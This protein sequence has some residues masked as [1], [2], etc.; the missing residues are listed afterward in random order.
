MFQYIYNMDMWTT[1]LDF[2]SQLEPFW[3]NLIGGNLNWCWNVWM[4]LYKIILMYH[5]NM[6][7]INLKEYDEYE[8]LKDHVS[9][10]TNVFG[11]LKTLK[12]ISNHLNLTFWWESFYVHL[13]I[14]AWN[15]FW[16]IR[17]LKKIKLILKI[18]CK[19]FYF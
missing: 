18:F 8:V 17:I 10:I 15:I 3:D 6:I 19:L 1:F 7:L 2:C 5:E 9:M 4:N 14:I 13:Y 16:V 11:C 12:W